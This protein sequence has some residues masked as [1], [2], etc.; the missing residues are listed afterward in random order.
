M[1]HPCQQFP[2]PGCTQ[3]SYRDYPKLS[4]KLQNLPR[5]QGKERCPLLVP[6]YPGDPRHVLWNSSPI[7]VRSTLDPKHHPSN[8]HSSTGV[9]WLSLANV[10][11]R[12]VDLPS[13]PFSL[14][15]VPIAAD[16]T[17]VSATAQLHPAPPGHCSLHRDV[18]QMDMIPL[19][20]Q[21]SAFL[22]RAAS[23]QD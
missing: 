8:D 7:E 5:V 6:A 19:G 21:H 10:G 11:L 18:R 20:F 16:E 1:P 4:R 2:S 3:K 15:H 13:P 12:Q 23:N 17:Q 14:S 9:K 22:L